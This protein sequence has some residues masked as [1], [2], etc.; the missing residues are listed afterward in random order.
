MR[1]KLL[2][3]S[4]EFDKLPRMMRE[5]VEFFD[6]VH[7]A[8]TGK[9]A[10]VTCVFGDAKGRVSKTHKEGRAVD[11]RVE[12]PGNF[13]QPFFYVTPMQA[14]KI[15]ERVNKRFPISQYMMACLV[16]RAVWM[17]DG[18]EHHGPLHFHLQIPGDWVDSH[19]AIT[20][21]VA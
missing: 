1:F 10:V 19:E 3:L 12:M 6:F 14:Q 18:V 7:K 17:E 11:C 20:P 4:E 21:S 9:E 15:A 16:H 5:V 8:E 13:G 2:E